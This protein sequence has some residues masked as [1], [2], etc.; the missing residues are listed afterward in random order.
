MIQRCAP[1]GQ[2]RQL[3]P[4]ETHSAAHGLPQTDPASVERTG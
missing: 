3:S 1:Y 2:G 4:D